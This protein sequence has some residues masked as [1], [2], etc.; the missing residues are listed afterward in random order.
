GPG[1]SLDNI[2]IHIDPVPF[3]P[4]NAG[5]AKVL[6]DNTKLLVNWDDN[7]ESDLAGYNVYRSLAS[8]GPYAQVNVSLLTNSEYL[9]S[10]LTPATTYYYILTAVDDDANESPYSSV[11]SEI[12]DAVVSPCLYGVIISDTTWDTDVL[13]CG[14]IYIVETATLTISPGVEVVFTNNSDINNIGSSAADIEIIVDG[15]VIADGESGNEIIFKADGPGYNGYYGF[16]LSEKIDPTITKFDECYFTQGEACIILVGPEEFT[17]TNSSFNSCGY[18]IFNFES[19]NVNVSNCDFY[20]TANG[21]TGYF[22]NLS[23]QVTNCTFTDSRYPVL[24]MDSSGNFTISNSTFINY[25]YG[26]DCGTTSPPD[27]GNDNGNITVSNSYFY[28]GENSFRLLTIPAYVTINDCTFNSNAATII[29]MQSK[30]EITVNN[31]SFS[32]SGTSNNFINVQFS[33]DVNINNST[34]TGG[35]FGFYSD[36]LD[37]VIIDGSSFDNMAIGPFI[38]RTENFQV[39]NST[40]MNNTYGFQCNDVKKAEYY[41]IFISTI[42]EIGII[43]MNNIESIYD[44]IT[45]NS[46]RNGISLSAAIPLTSAK[47]SDLDISNFSRYGLQVINLDSF[48]MR[49]SK[50]K[51]GEIGGLYMGLNYGK[52]QNNTISNMNSSPG[53]GFFLVNIPGN[54]E[55]NN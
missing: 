49:D 5:V 42:S 27:S 16:F 2:N 21:V 41:D 37:E 46:V 45:I 17:V 7:I 51:G 6:G 31:S 19:S 39:L 33:G 22:E 38:V 40:S 55:I 29:A 8:T 47:I 34:F 44:N 15:N 12:T 52:F 50:I 54:L 23:G 36:Y 25:R 35:N 3:A 43:G 14:D 11:V 26:V 53:V 9:D 20:N 10:G 30:G 18:A 28:D 24:K 13:I 4:Q 48:E 32:D 1:C